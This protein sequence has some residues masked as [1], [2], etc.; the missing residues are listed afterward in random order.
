MDQ[1]KYIGGRT[2]RTY[3]RASGQKI[4]KDDNK[5][6]DAI[7]AEDFNEYKSFSRGILNRLKK[8]NRRPRAQGNNGN[9][10]KEHQQF[11]T[12]AGDASHQ[13]TM[14]SIPRG[15]TLKIYSS[16]RHDASRDKPKFAEGRLGRCEEGRGGQDITQRTGNGFAHFRGLTSRTT[17]SRRRSW[18]HGFE[19]GLDDEDTPFP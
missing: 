12:P 15:L 11:D 14:V 19:E 17:S 3:G 16:S 18:R 8:G 7:W 2:D 13:S 6:S 5:I 1:M 4:K 10:I 9:E